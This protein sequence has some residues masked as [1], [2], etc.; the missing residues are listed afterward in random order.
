[1]VGADL[2]LEELATFF[3]LPIA[4]AAKEIGVC[5]TVLKKICRKNKVPRWPHRKIKSLNKSIEAL[6]RTLAHNPDQ[7]AI[8]SSQIFDLKAKRDTVM[9]YPETIVN[10]GAGIV[11]PSAAGAN[12]K[13][14]RARMSSQRLQQAQQ[15][16][17]AHIQATGKRTER[18]STN[19]KSSRVEVRKVMN[20]RVSTTPSRS[21]P[22]PPMN[23]QSSN[24]PYED[25][26]DWSS[27]SEAPNYATPPTSPAAD[28]DSDDSAPQ[29]GQNRTAMHGTEHEAPHHHS[30][31]MQVSVNL[32]AY[33]RH[34][35]PQNA[36]GWSSQQHPM[37]PS[38]SH[39]GMEEHHHLDFGLLMSETEAN[40]LI[41]ESEPAFESSLARS[42]SSSLLGSFSGSP[43]TTVSSASTSLANSAS[44]SPRYAPG[45]PAH[46]SRSAHPAAY[47]PVPHHGYAYSLPPHAT[48]GHHQPGMSY[49]QFATSHGPPHMHMSSPA[50]YAHNM[51]SGANDHFGPH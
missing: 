3:H 35:M 47:H 49:T 26:S 14:K 20:P 40:H 23:S 38:R 50:Y 25:S 33:H 43:S 48:Y 8:I 46:P 16:L 11:G 7:R 18:T 15:S 21:T 6:E 42:R 51:H 22:A 37:H 17:I 45:P 31:A 28:F 27:S 41:M 2:N 44:T 5:A 30:T 13:R 32:S 1:M 29:E 19:N 4:L 39:P 36:A 9:K 34:F 12:P 10:G 24:V